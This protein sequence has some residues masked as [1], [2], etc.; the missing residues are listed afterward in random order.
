MVVAFNREVDASLVNF[1][2]VRL[3]RLAS[4]RF[5]ALGPPVPIVSAPAPGDPAAIVIRP[6][7]SLGAGT[8]RVTLRGTG[9]GALADL[10][11]ITLEADYYFVFTVEVAP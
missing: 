11:A 3:E 7:T 9:G 2:T 6:V 5:S 10:N 1:T 4:D 8:Y